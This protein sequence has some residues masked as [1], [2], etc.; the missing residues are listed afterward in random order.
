MAEGLAEG[1]NIRRH[2]RDYFCQRVWDNAFHLVYQRVT[3]NAFHLCASTQRGGYTDH[4][5]PITSHPGLRAAGAALGVPFAVGWALA[6]EEVA[7]LKLQWLSRWPWAW[8]S[9]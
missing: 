6:W 9:L 4:L 1:P 3:E 8:P 5:S 7:E 2:S